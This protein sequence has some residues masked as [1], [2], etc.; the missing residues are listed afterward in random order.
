MVVIFDNAYTVASMSQGLSDAERAAFDTI[1]SSL[2]GNSLT[3]A[4][5]RTNRLRLRGGVLL[6]LVGVV[7]CVVTFTFSVTLALGCLALSYVGFLV[8]FRT[9]LHPWGPSWLSPSISTF[10]SRFHHPRAQ[11]HDPSNTRDHP[12]SL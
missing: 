9:V 2:D 10:F 3:R 4:A 5:S 7:G 11:T 6:G 1:A 12:R 8:A